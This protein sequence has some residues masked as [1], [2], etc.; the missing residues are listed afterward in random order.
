MIPIWF[1]VVVAMYTF[2]AGV[3][4]MSFLVVFPDHYERLGRLGHK[5]RKVHVITFAVGATFGTL[6]WFLTLVGVLNEWRKDQQ[7]DVYS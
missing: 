1:A 4:A 5:Q 2:V 7:A 3:F 6:F